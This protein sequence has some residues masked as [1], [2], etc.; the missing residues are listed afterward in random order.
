[1]DS[2]ES[3]ARHEEKNRILNNSTTSKNAALLLSRK[4]CHPRSR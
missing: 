4:Y 3:K 2:Q 1:M